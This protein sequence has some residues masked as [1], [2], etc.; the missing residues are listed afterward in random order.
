M[1]HTYYSAALRGIEGQIVT[2]E[3]SSVPSSEYHLEI[4]GLP[5]TAV[6]EAA[7][8]VRSAGRDLNLSMKTGKITV[9]LAPADI[10]KEGTI[11]DLPILLSLL[12]PEEVRN[13]DFSSSVF[14]G[15]L[16]LSG[17][18]RPINGALPMALSAAANGF[19]HFFCPTEN[20]PEASAAPGINVYP[21]HDV[22]EILLH[23]R[24]ILPIEPLQFCVE[25]ILKTCFDGAPDFSE[26]KGQETAKKA[27]E[28]AAA[29]MH[30]VMLIGPPGSGKSMLAS[31][32]PH[33]LPPLTYEEAIESSKIYSVAGLSSELNPLLTRRPFRSPHHNISSAALAG[34]GSHAQPGEIS[35]AHNGVLFL[36]EFP[37]FAPKARETIRQPLE[38][39]RVTISRVAGS[40]TFPCSFMLVC[41]MNPC[42]CGFYGHPTKSCSCSP[43]SKNTYLGRVSGPV[44]DRIDIQVEVGALE[45]D[46]LHSA[47]ACETSEQIRAR[48]TKARAFALERFDGIRL[49]NGS[50]LTANALME[51]QHLEL[52]CRLDE[53]A[54]ELIR[55]AFDKLSLSARGYNRLLKVA[56]TIADFEECQQIGKQHVATAIRMRSLDR[57]YFG[58]I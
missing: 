23:F 41:A 32:L 11:Y 34:G 1:V 37:E 13:A 27:L 24:G 8:R 51:P 12:K 16:S 38:E 6:K 35:L 29:G 20:A 3:A 52:F 2:V 48:V 17:T 19:Q 57:K 14:V 56:R 10:R 26:V 30:N 42:P 49:R 36:D 47:V 40:A 31:R 39:H 28:V 15:E 33:I 9:N 5:D 55:R 46:D 25:S 21:V 54:K 43:K 18:L 58:S 53:D 22:R 45:F 7:A 44:L 50:P 4:I